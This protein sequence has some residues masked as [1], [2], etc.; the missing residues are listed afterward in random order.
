MC[1][2]TRARAHLPHARTHKYLNCKSTLT[3]PVCRRNVTIHDGSIQLA[4][5][6]ANTHTHT[7]HVR[8]TAQ[9]TA[10]VNTVIAALPGLSIFAVKADGTIICERQIAGSLLPSFRLRLIAYFGGGRGAARIEERRV[11]RMLIVVG[12]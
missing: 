12:D 11:R 6:E 4:V 2:A 8:L 9:P 7:H 3:I 10:A 5:E 1:H